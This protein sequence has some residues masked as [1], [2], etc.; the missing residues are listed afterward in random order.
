[1]VDTVDV[2]GTTATSL[3]RILVTGTML[4]RVANYA[5]QCALEQVAMQWHVCDDKRAQNAAL[6]ESGVQVCHG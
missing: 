2:T 3:A 5:Q 4:P 1:M 6:G